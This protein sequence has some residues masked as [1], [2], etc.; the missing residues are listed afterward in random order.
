MTQTITQEDVLKALTSV[1]LDGEEIDLVAGGQISGI[2][3]KEGHIGF[4]LEIDPAKAEEATPLKNAAESAVL[5]LPGVLSATAMLTVYSN[6][7]SQWVEEDRF[8]DVL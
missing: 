6:V 7:K 5:A 3:I 2:I 1:S 4:S 8:E